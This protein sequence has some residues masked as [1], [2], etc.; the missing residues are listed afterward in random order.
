MTVEERAKEI[1]AL[2]IEYS[3]DG[4]H[5]TIP[6]PIRLA[7]FIAQRLKADSG[8]KLVDHKFADDSP[9]ST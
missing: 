5:A 4:D 8:R 7:E 3:S 6:E 1:H 9:A 2:L